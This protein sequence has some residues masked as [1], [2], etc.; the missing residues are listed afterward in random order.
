[1]RRFISILALVS[2]P[3]LA[4]AAPIPVR[5][6]IG[7]FAIQPTKSVARVELTQV[8][9]AP[10]QEMPA[11]MHPVPVIC[12]VTKGVFLVSIGGA[13]VRRVGVGATTIE[14]AGTIVHYFRNVSKI[15]GQLNCAF[16]AGPDDKTLSVML[17]QTNR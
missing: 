1:M 14:P 9:F 17:E 3:A 6:P 2:F 4:T 11:H 12:F 5:T 13:P 10:G 8:D 15:P 16:L 7:S